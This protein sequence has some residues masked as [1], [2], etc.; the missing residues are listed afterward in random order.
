MIVIQC[1][2]VCLK[3]MYQHGPSLIISGTHSQHTLENGVLVLVTLFPLE[4]CDKNYV[5][6]QWKEDK[7]F[8]NNCFVNRKDVT[9]S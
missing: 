5:C 3:K 1:V 2:V 9:L 7:G 4:C 6:K 8:D